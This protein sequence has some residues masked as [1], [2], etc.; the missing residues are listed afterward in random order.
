MTIAS[1]I[2]TD[3]TVKA[4]I[5]PFEGVM[6]LEDYPPHEPFVT[7]R[8][9]KTNANKFQWVNFT[10]DNTQIKDME[11]FTRFNTWFVNNETLRVTISGKTKVQPKGLNRKS[12][13]DFKK[14]LELKGLNLFKGTKVNNG[15][16]DLSKKPPAHNFFADVVL[17]NP[18]HFTLDIGNATFKNIFRNEG[19][20]TNVGDLFIQNLFLKPGDNKLKVEGALDQSKVVNAIGAAGAGGLVP[21]HLIG[22]KVTYHGKDLPY[23][24]DA[25][26]NADQ[27]I[28]LN[29]T[30]VLQNSN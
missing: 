17:P 18:S 26:A 6:Y 28:E 11:A 3:G 12:K 1:S 19:K 25:L 8:F 24:A 13:V 22:K 30:E 4:D 14:T 10:Q 9:P 27:R 5:D 16:V 21:F 29:V 2:K 15:R 7:L 23:F 20:D